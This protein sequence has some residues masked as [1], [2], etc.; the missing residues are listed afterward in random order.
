MLTGLEESV[1]RDPAFDELW[2]HGVIHGWLAERP[3]IP[4]E[5]LNRRVYDTLFS[6][7]ADDP[8]L[9]LWSAEIYDGLPGP[10][11]R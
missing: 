1:R 7:P 11:A 3:E 10:T 2:L 9:G 6:T 8:W 4:L 5:A